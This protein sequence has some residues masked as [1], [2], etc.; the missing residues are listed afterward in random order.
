MASPLVVF[1]PAGAAHANAIGRQGFEQL[2]IEF[3]PA[4]LSDV[5]RD[6]LREVRSWKGGR[7]AIAARSLSRLWLDQ[8]SDEQELV[9]GTAQFLKVAFES[10]PAREPVWLAKVVAGLSDTSP[11]SIDQLARHAGIR[12]AWL[13]QAY[14]AAMGEG[15]RQTMLR[16]RVECAVILLRETS[17]PAADIAVAAGFYDQSHMIRCFQALLARTPS[18]VRAEASSLSAHAAPEAAPQP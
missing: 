14:N 2:D 3:D 11:Q 10:E 17:L 18:V 12:P 4:W 1:Q 16:K 6:R 9:A 7:T 13:G 15:L 5:Q 8:T